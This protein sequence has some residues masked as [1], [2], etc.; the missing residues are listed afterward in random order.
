MKN[1]VNGRGADIRNEGK[2]N[3]VQA[4]SYFPSWQAYEIYRQAT[5]GLVVMLL[6]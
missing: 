6:I 2:R 1:N 5:I 4:Y 3:L